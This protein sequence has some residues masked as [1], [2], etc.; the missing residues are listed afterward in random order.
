[1][2][3]TWPTPR[4]SSRSSVTI[5]ENRTSRVVFLTAVA[6]ANARNWAIFKKLMVMLKNVFIG[7]TRL[8]KSS[9]AKNRMYFYF[10]HAKF[11]KAV[12]AGLRPLVSSRERSW[13]MWFD[14][15]PLVV[16]KCVCA[17]SLTFYTLFGRVFF[18]FLPTLELWLFY[19]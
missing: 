8:N 3:H 16:D 14:L 4:R 13:Y 10:R 7:R 11:L 5:T 18:F 19:A 1:M 6:V 17:A 2:T 9:C 15:G 12:I